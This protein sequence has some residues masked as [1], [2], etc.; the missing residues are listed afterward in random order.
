VSVETKISIAM[1][2]YNGERFIQEQ[3]ESFVRQTR[4]PDE[5][6]ISDNCSTD[7]TVAIVRDFVARA[8]FPVKLY[9]NA[10]NIGMSKNFSQAIERCAGNIIF[11]SDCDDFWLP[12][13]L[14]TVEAH[15]LAAAQV[16][17]V[18][19]DS[20]LVSELL[21]PLGRTLMT[22]SWFRK[23]VRN[24]VA[25][26][27]PA[28]LRRLPPFAGHAMAF[29]ADYRPWFLPIP[30]LPAFQRGGWDTWIGCILAS[31]TRMVIVAKPLVLY[32][33]YAAQSSGG[34][35]LWTRAW[36]T[37]RLQ[38]RSPHYYRLRADEAKVISDRLLANGLS[39]R[40]KWAHFLSERH[41]HF[42]A[43]AQIRRM[44]RYRTFLVLRELLA[45]RYRRH[46]FGVLSAAKDLLLPDADRT[47][48]LCGLSQTLS[49]SR[50]PKVT[51]QLRRSQ[52]H[53]SSIEDEHR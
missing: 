12:H 29:R 26:F 45:L 34:G 6:V 10:R 46:S 17:L 30:D 42:A 52:R 39:P 24:G 2:V 33:Q 49:A 21:H 20:Q 9:V 40:N 50:E 3:L 7:R 15:F 27:D 14:A 1:A 43:R 41:R 19:C 8:P 23:N 32:R 36:L 47:R 28:D 53:I 25:T 16:G 51:E 44:A 22:G 4:L 13:K 18:L 31:Q 38:E 5:L 11:P 48:K 37:R 35:D